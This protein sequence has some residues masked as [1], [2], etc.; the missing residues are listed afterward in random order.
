[1]GSGNIRSKTSRSSCTARSCRL[2]KD[3]IYLH[4]KTV[5]MIW[6][7]IL[8]SVARLTRPH[9]YQGSSERIA[10]RQSLCLSWVPSET[11]DDITSEA[12][13]PYAM[14]AVI[15]GVALYGDEIRLLLQGIFC[16]RPPH[17]TYGFIYRGLRGLFC[18][19]VARQL[20]AYDSVCSP[21]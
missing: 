8:P 16:A 6:P 15:T 4:T 13:F 9:S 17:S 20:E 7:R 14:V 5:I 12:R 10:F 18:T 2:W 1:M 21:C 11:S 19:W 3:S